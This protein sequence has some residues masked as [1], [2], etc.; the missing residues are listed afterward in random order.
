MFGLDWRWCAA[1]KSFLRVASYAELGSAIPINGGARAYLD[2]IFGPIFGFLFSWTAITV[3]KPSGH[4]LICLIFAEHINRAIFCD[5]SSNKLVALLCLW[6]IIAI[7]SAGSRWATELNNVFTFAKVA[8]LI[9]IAVTGM[10]LLGMPRP[11]MLICSP[12]AWGAK[13]QPQSFR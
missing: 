8:T 11:T 12:G 1:F 6:S 4:G 13:F 5:E 2:H 7:Q 3:L 9:G 10:T